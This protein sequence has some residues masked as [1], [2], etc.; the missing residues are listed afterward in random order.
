MVLFN[1]SADL[2]SNPDLY[3]AQLDKL[4]QCIDARMNNLPSNVSTDNAQGSVDVDAKSSGIIVNGCGWI[5]DVGYKLM[6]HTVEA[7]RINVVLVMGHDRLYSM[8]NGYYKKLGQSKDASG[9]GDIVDADM[10]MDVEEEEIA[11]PKVIKLP[12]SGGVVSRDTAFRSVAKSLCMKRYFYGESLRPTSG[13]AA[14]MLGP[15][16]GLDLESICPPSSSL[17]HQYGPTLLEIP[18]ADLTLYKLSSVS[19]S[20]SMLPVSAKQ[21]TDPVQLTKVVQIEPNMK[22]GILAVCHPNAV[23]K[24]QESGEAKDLYLAAVSGMVAVETVTSSTVSISVCPSDTATLVPSST[25]PSARD[26]P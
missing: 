17:V 23:E 21:A 20:A 13:S 26:D 24:F 11:V 1:G 22:H 9:K 5:E 3:K 14:M 15:G 19:L 18:F 6:L 2:K 12:R 16:G 25:F 8:L 4:G 10:L 7:L